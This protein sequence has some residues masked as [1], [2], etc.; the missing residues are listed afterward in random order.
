MQNKIV[1]FDAKLKHRAKGQTDKD[2]R[3]VINFNYEL[4]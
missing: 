4:N 1:I 3:I 2:T